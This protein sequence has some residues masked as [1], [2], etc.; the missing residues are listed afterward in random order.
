MRELV[1]SVALVLL[2]AVLTAAPDRAQDKTVEGAHIRLSA[3]ETGWGKEV[4]GLQA[5]LVRETVERPYRVGETVSFLFRVRNVGDRVVSLLYTPP[6]FRDWRPRVIDAA[7]AEATVVVPPPDPNAPEV[8]PQTR[9]LVPGEGFDL[10]RSQFTIRP[11]GWDRQLE[12]TAVLAAPGHYKVSQSYRFQPGRPQD[13]IWSGESETGRLELEVIPAE[14]TPTQKEPEDVRP[15]EE[16]PRLIRLYEEKQVAVEAGFVPDEMDIVLGQPLFITFTITNRADEP[17]V[18]EVGG[19]EHDSVRPNRFRITAVDADGQILR[20]PHL[21]LGFVGKGQEVT[22]KKGEAYAERLFLPHW[23]AVEK[24]GPYRVTCR[25]AVTESVRVAT[26]FPLNVVPFD[27]T[28]MRGVIAALGKKVREQDGQA[29]C[30]AT[31]ALAMI[32][33]EG[34]IAH[35]AV[36]LGKGD[37]ENRLLAIA[38]LSQFDSDAA[39]DALVSALRQEDERV[40]SAAVAS[41]DRMKKTG[42]AVDRLAEELADEHPPVRVG[43]ARAL[44]A[45]KAR[46]A[47]QPLIKALDD[48]EAAVRR[49]AAEALGALG[50]PQAIGPLREHLEDQDMG[51]RLSVVKGLHALDVPLESAW[52]AAAVRAATDPEDETFRESIRLIR[53]HA[54]DGAAR[55]L[56]SCLRF[57][58]PSPRHLYNAFLIEQIRACAGAPE[59]EAAYYSDPAS[60]GTPEQIESNRRM[61]AQV[62]AWLEGA[63]VSPVVAQDDTE[64]GPA[65]EP[66]P[67]RPGERR[68]RA[69]R[70]AGR[71]T[72]RSSHS[73]KR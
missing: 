60:D 73:T 34:A 15:A 53:L 9:R 50:Q 3:D 11:V 25:R 21:S 72:D 38:G 6:D 58:D 56:A 19:D 51:V 18:F 29:L 46:S 55:V 62:K 42:R 7:G 32:P 69:C 12:E 63:E 67:G 5:G 59:W 2:M 40:R 35:L 16:E 54:G 22:L 49:A 45:T 27:R 71:R 52:L 39:A 47:L 36:S 48:R 4:R 30:E 64:R 23:C 44:A 33:D 70:S 28:R 41:L 17:Y 68:W 8:L 14:A 26:S 13:N 61:L 65:E 10:G 24:P 66:E 31:R 20:D 57:D 1:K 37:H 43:A